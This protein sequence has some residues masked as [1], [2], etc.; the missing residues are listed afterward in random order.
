MTPYEDRAELM[1]LATELA[2]ERAELLR[3][4]NAM[5]NKIISALVNEADKLLPAAA[6]SSPEAKGQKHTPTPIEIADH[7]T[8]GRHCGLCG[9][10]GHDARTCTKGR[11]EKPAKVR[12]QRRPLTEEEK[13]KR[14]ANL[15]KARAARGAKK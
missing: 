4:V 1:K 7:E 6:E 13:E 12:K 10:A 14:R 5:Y 11:A 2:E 15:V 9:E 8:P 3:K